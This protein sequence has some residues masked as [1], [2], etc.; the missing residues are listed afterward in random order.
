VGTV[1]PVGALRIES[2][3]SEKVCTILQDTFAPPPPGKLRTVASQGA[4][5]LI[6]EASQGPDVTGYVVLRGHTPDEP[7]A[8]IT[9]IP[10]AE[11]SYRDTVPSGGRF[12]YAVRAVDSAGN[13]G[14]ASAPIEDVAR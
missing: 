13:V 7:L 5:N 10:I 9:P 8:P 1:R 2:V 4:I 14:P 3:P 12:T 6:W 11:T